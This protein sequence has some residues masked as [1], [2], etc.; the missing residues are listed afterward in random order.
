VLDRPA[1]TDV[2]TVEDALAIEVADGLQVELIEGAIRV[3]PPPLGSLQTVEAE[4]MGYFFRQGR[5]PRAN[6]G[7]KIDE[8]D[9]L[10]PDVVVLKKG[11][12][13]A[14]GTNKQSPA[15]VD[16][17]IE[18]VSRSSRGHDRL[19]KPAV[20]ARVG[21]P[22]YWRAEPTSAGHAIYPHELQDG[23]YVLTR[24]VEF[25]ALLAED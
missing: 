9:F 21:I 25:D 8:V 10:I 24:E 15:I 23:E 7:L 17:A 20:Y 16:I 4:L 19:I 13:L 12:E 18:I 6:V 2:W 11:E 3:A 14:P 5:R 1:Q 22:Q